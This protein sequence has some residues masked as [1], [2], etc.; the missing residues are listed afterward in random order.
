MNALE[1]KLALQLEQKKQQSLTRTHKVLQSPQSINPVIDGKKLLSFNSNDYLGLANHPALISAFTKAANECGVGSGSA[2]LVSGHHT[3]HQQLE[4]QLAAKTGYPRALLFSTGYMANLAIGN[5]VGRQDTIFQDKLNHASLI[6]SAALSPA[7]IKRYKHLDYKQC[8]EQLAHSE[9]QKL[10]MTD[11]VFSMDGDQADLAHLAKICQ[12]QNATLMIDDAHGFG[13]LGKTGAGS[14]EQ[15][16]LSSQD[17]PIYMATLGKAMGSFGAF[18]AASDTIIEA[19]IHLARP[20]VYTTAMPAAQAAASSA[21]LTL[22]DS[23]SWRRES[24][25]SNIQYFR[26]CATQSHLA[27]MNSQ[28]AIQPII[29]GENKAAVDASKKLWAKGIMASAIRPPTVPTGSARL[30]ITLCAEHTH[31][32]IDQLIDALII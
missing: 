24:L 19:L 12:Q 21:A 1:Q 17:I 32:H 28:T 23:E 2:H 14:A 3:Y 4:Q 13:V 27:L 31:Q 6:D 26:A 22:L 10:V 25:N 30:R 7:K 8:D 29:L 18:I 16:N 5:L 9:P 11:A 20:Y 15:E